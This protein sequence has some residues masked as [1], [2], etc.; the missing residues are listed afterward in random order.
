MCHPEVPAGEPIPNVTTLE[1]AVPLGA[2]EEM[3]G[4]LALPER[5][6]APAVLIVNDIFGRSSF[7]ENLVRRLALAGFV[8]YTPEF[9]FRVGPL[10]ERTREAAFAR[11]ARLDESDLLRDMGAAVEWLIAR[12]E[13]GGNPVGVIGF[14]MGGTVVLDFAQRPDIAAAVCYYGFPAAPRPDGKTSI[15]HAP[16]MRV[17]LLGFWGDQDAGVGMDSVEQLRAALERSGAPHEFHIYPGPGHGFL[18]AFLE[19]ENAPGYEAAC[20]SWTRALAFYREQLRA[21]TPA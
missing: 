15:D 9:F 2:G 10:P 19:D 18:A 14:C 16:E 6:P 17:P 4:L 8:G 5:M 20:N 3:P 21:L 13:V 12:P 7:Y 11:R 1:A